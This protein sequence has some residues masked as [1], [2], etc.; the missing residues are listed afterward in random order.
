MALGRILAGSVQLLL[1]GALTSA[2]VAQGLDRSCADPAVPFNLVSNFEIV[3]DGQLGDLSGLKFILDT[4]SSS[5]AIDRRVADRMGLR[6]RPG[7]VFNFDRNLAIEWAD[8]PEVRIGPVRVGSIA[9]MVTRLADLSALA[10]NAD[11]IIGMDVLSRARKL[12]IDYERR[13]I[14]FRMDEGGAGAPRTNSALVIPVMVQGI[15]MRVLV[16]TGFEYFLL[17]KDRVHGALPH[18]HTQGE[19][20]DA[21]L[22]RLQAVQVE[23]PGVEIAGA[24]RVTPVLLIDGPGNAALSG[25]DGYLGP[26]ALHARRVEFDFAGRTVRW[27]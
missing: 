12:C 8:V 20:R 3:V 9:M 2:A 4:G 11:G 23:L 5:S 19:P 6:R 10:G 1:A 21:I 18:L 13:R 15:S 16:D 27:Q 7:T 22:G 17:Y 24:Q 26:A 25:V 14:S